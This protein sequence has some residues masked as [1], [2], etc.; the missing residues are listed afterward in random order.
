LQRRHPIEFVPRRFEKRFEQPPPRR[1]DRDVQSAHRR[2][3]RNHRVHVGFNGDVAAQRITAQRCREPLQLA[4][5]APRHR[6]RR[7]LVHE[8]PRDRLAHVVLAARTQN[9]RAFPG[10]PAHVRSPRFEA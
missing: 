1:V 4:H 10:E 2:R 5:V 9:Q 6:D 3:I 8:P 7:A